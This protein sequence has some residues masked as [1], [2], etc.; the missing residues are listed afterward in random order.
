MASLLSELDQAIAEHA[1]V[2]QEISS[3]SSEDLAAALLQ[4]RIALQKQ[5]DINGEQRVDQLKI[6]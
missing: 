6:E 3:Q 5:V 4:L 1:G 2:A